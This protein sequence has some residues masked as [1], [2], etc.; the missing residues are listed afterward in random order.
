MAAELVETTRLWARVVAR[1]QPEWIEPLAEH[2]VRRNYSEPHWER[3]QG[4]VIAYERVTLYGV[5]IVTQRKVNYGRIE[6]QLSRELFIRN[7][8]VEGDWET[9]HKFFHD[10]QDL[11]AEVEEL[12]D[13]ARRRDILVDDEVLFGFYD[14]LIGEDVVSARHFDAWWKRVRRNDPDLLTFDK[15]MLVTD[16]ASEVTEADYPEIWLLR[17]TSD[18][19]S[20]QPA[21]QPTP[22]AS[23]QHGRHGSGRREVDTPTTKRSGVPGGQKATGRGL[24]AARHENAGSPAAHRS[25]H[26]DRPDWR[27]EKPAPLRVTYQ[28]EP[29]AEADGVTVHIPL[30]ALE[31]VRHERF[32][33]QVPGLRE[34]LVTALIRSLPKALRRSF[35]PIPDHARAALAGIS[36]ADGPLLDVLADRLSRTAGVRISRDAFD[37][38]RV[39]AHLTM[40]YRVEDDDGQVVAEGKDLD[41]IRE[42]VR[43]ATRANLSAVAGALE[44][45][46]LRTWEVGTLP[47]V[48]RDRREGYEVRAYPA[49]VD[50][51]ASV[52]VKL[53]D[54][55]D[56]QA[57]AM[58]AGTRRLLLLDT[59]APIAH[60]SSRL[61]NAAKLIL[62]RNPHGGV[63]ALLGDCSG[64]AV[65]LMIAESGGPP[66][67]EA[68][69]VRLREQVRA[70]LN[71][72]VLDVVGRV[73]PILAAVQHIEQRLLESPPGL[74]AD[75]LADIRAHLSRLVYPGFVTATG[76]QRLPDILRYLQAI[77][78]R[79]DK[80]PAN[81]AR[82]RDLT[83][84]IQE[85][86]REYDEV[87]AGLP[88]GTRS[89]DDVV[90]VR[91]MLEELRIS[92]FAQAQRTAFPVSDKR[93]SRALDEI[94]AKYAAGAGT[95]ATTAATTGNEVTT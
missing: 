12:E 88:P 62:A 58:W 45:H 7:A 34:E 22:E 9:H 31:H 76:Y 37:L 85:V 5:P 40:T 80:L 73:Q 52:G 51:G 26:P 25:D 50:E 18:Q 32:D 10:N 60:I 1:I 21:G 14:Q 19:N 61:S 92:Y 43:P 91:W 4:A 84:R 87:V 41:R 53:F 86:E 71:A 36:P 3:D 79:L 8:L 78:Y 94:E 81:S 13:R 47:K 2:L 72:S 83:V 15:Q 28:F 69:F 55:P 20:G 30:P 90:A 42:E 33:W 59:P 89:H 6:P 17:Q 64:A 24:R 49:L 68:S 93:I 65:D 23:G 46:S 66:W 27:A 95:P 11:L 67:D 74:L 35:V 38:D 29:G 57:A 56:E 16:S 44:R 48:V 77:G 75:S 39:P 70:E 63:G 54:T 82:D